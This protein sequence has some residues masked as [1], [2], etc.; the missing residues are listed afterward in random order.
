[1]ISYDEIE[2]SKEL[3]ERIEIYCQQI[4]EFRSEGPLDTVSLAKLEEHFKASHIYHGAG[5]EGNRLTL[6]ETVLVLKEGIEI[7]GD[8]LPDTLEVK[9]LGAAFDFLKTLANAEQTLRET[10]VR[11]LHRLLIGNDVIKC[12]ANTAEW[13]W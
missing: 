11:D 3:R 1:M 13:V 7:R 9:N 8:K 4:Q 10:D 5:I 6:Q 12:P 2:I